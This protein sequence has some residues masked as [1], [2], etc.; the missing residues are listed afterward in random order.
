MTSIEQ[1]DL[2]RELRDALF[3]LEK[4]MIKMINRGDSK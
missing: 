3:S 2:A 4:V 1:L